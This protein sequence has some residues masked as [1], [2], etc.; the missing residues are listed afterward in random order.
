MCSFAYL[1]SKI[2]WRIA[3][4]Y[5]MLVVV[6]LGISRCC[7]SLLD[8]L[9]AALVG[10]G[11]FELSSR[12]GYAQRI[13]GILEKCLL[14]QIAGSSFLCISH[15]LLASMGRSGVCRQMGQLGCVGMRRLSQDSS[16]H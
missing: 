4:S 3:A 11:S 7:Y 2:A 5:K 10:N 9:D 12:R 1:R 14:A 15:L 13:N 8:G 6:F 16:R